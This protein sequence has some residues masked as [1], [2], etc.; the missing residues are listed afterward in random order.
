MDLPRPHDASDGQSTRQLYEKKKT[1]LHSLDRYTII[2][3]TC[4]ATVVGESAVGAV[5]DTILSLLPGDGRVKSI[6]ECATGFR[7]FGESELLKFAGSCAQSVFDE[8]DSL[9]QAIQSS[10][11]P[12]FPPGNS[13]YL[14]SL[15]TALA[16]F[17]T[18]DVGD[19]KGAVA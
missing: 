13:P 5:Q 8:A 19:R 6:A 10:R 1:W 11:A 2:E 18:D 16:K 9:L 12:K 7:S 15:K 17:C 3:R 14:I 4:F